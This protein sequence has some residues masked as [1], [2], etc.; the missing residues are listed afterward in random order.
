MAR[1]AR[2]PASGSSFHVWTTGGGTGI[3]IGDGRPPAVGVSGPIRA[4]EVRAVL[5]LK[6][7]A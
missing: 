6:R 2:Y 7:G 3:Q 1:A 5:C 4:G